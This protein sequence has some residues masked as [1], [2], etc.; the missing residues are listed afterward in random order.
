M[1]FDTRGRRRHVIRVVY[2]VLA[3]LMGASL[4]LVVGPFN[5][6]ELGGDGGSSSANEVFEDR[7]ERIE[8]RL[9]A[10]PEDEDL[11]LILSRTRIGAGNALLDT[12][13]QT[14]APIVTPEAQVQ[15]E[16]GLTAWRRY[17]E[18]AKEPNPVAASLVA[19][20]YF[21]LAESSTTFEETQEFVEGAAEAQALAAKARPSPG[22][23]STLA[24]YEYFDGNFADGDKAS[25][26]AQGL[27]RGKAEKKE[28]ASALA[29]YRK[30]AQRFVKQTREFEKTQQA[31]GGEESFENA[32]GGLGGGAGLGASSP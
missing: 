22:A 2:A 24:I 13:P 10:S 6:G 1:L 32:L 16:A 7:A 27:V 11:L 25:E 9:K 14:G 26:E 4:F 15:F 23:L 3:L 18:Q 17:L 31:G 8:D 19:G 20:T 30:N 29:P 28:I 12:D 5:L 21:S